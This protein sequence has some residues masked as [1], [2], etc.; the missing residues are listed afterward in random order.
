[1][2]QPS[3]PLGAGKSSLDLIDQE[4]LFPALSLKPGEAVLDLGCGEGRYTLPVASRVG[5]QGT[6]YAV[7]LWE[8]G[9]ARLGEK[10]GRGGLWPTYG[11][12]MPTSA[13]PCPCPTPA[14]M[15]P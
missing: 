2:T 6:V 15:W 5:P 11:S 8:E 3:H 7:D 13:G 10:A 4:L 14:S 9:L 1:M 12:S